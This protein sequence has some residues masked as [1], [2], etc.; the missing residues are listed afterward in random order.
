VKT[1]LISDPLSMTAFKEGIAH[2]GV[3]MKIMLIIFIH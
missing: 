2:S 3:P 1:A